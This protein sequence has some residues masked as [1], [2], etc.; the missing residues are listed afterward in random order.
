E[1]KELLRGAVASLKEINKTEN[2]DQEGKFKISGLAQGTYLLSVQ[3][4]GYTAYETELQVNADVQ[5]DVLLQETSIL[6]DE[7]LITS[8]RAKEN[9]PTTYSNLSK[10][11]IAKQNYGQDLPLLLNW[12]PS[13]VTTSDAGAGV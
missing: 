6:T 3:F 5:L 1:H 2:T 9:T 7:V 13:L 11:A 10:Q 12:M 8:L 4:L